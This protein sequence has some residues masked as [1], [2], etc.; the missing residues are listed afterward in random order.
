MTWRLSLLFDHT[1]SIQSVCPFKRSLNWC[2]KINKVCTEMHYYFYSNMARLLKKDIQYVTEGVLNDRERCFSSSIIFKQV[3]GL[4]VVCARR[5]R[6]Q[7]FIAGGNW[8]PIRYLREQI[9]GDKA[10]ADMES[11]SVSD[12][13]MACWLQ[14]KEN[15]DQLGSTSLQVINTTRKGNKGIT[16]MKN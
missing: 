12:I 8:R 14:G 6:R 10:V 5:G 3:I 15:A 4:H 13:T 7:E 1:P 9:Y 16:H 11:I 2:E